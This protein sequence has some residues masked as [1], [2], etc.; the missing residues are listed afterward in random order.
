LEASFPAKS[1]RM[2]HS[3]AVKRATCI[4]TFARK[5]TGT[6]PKDKIA[7]RG[8]LE[9]GC[10][11][12]TTVV[13]NRKKKVVQAQVKKHVE[14]GAAL[15]T[16]AL[17][18]YSG[19]EKDFDPG[20]VDHALEYVNGRIHTNSLENFWSLL[21]RGLGETYIS[22]EPFHLFR[23]LDEQAFRYNNR[24]HMNDGARSVKVIK[25]IVGKRL[26][27]AELIGKASESP[28]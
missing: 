22:V 17:R 20:F 25:Q 15:Y 6:G 26:T 4:K 18:S 14:K 16:D 3:S 12:R 28:T 5:I 2:R 24:K 13:P 23:Y 27:Y 10:K 11:V 1:K 19:L 8:I 21:K 9:R 7:V